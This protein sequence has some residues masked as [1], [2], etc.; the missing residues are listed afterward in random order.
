VL[1]V[2]AD[3]QQAAAAWAQ[4]VPRLEV[5]SA[6][7]RRLDGFL[8]QRAAAY[9]AVVVDS[10]PGF[11]GPV[12]EALRVS[13]L[14]VIPV[15]PTPLDARAVAWVLTAAR[16]LRG[17]AL[18]VRLVLSRVHARTLLAREAREALAGYGVSVARAE[19][20]ERTAVATAFGL[21]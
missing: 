18:D 9:D 10:A 1:L 8:E 21:G 12:R 16:D 19:V 6:P 15:Q 20:A 2:D 17:P 7:G 13:D 4:G 14:L 5:A 3:E 11:S